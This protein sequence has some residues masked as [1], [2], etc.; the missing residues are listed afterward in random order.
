MV[1]VE[2][3]SQE[4]ARWEPA[5]GAPAPMRSRRAANASAPLQPM[6]APFFFPGAA[7]EADP[8]FVAHAMFVARAPA[9]AAGRPADTG[10]EV[11]RSG[12]ATAAL[13]RSADIESI[14]GPW[15]TPGGAS[16]LGRGGPGRQPGRRERLVRG[17]A[18]DLARIA[19]A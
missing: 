15:Y 5:T 8:E 14:E 9:F 4:I 19:R 3:V 6:H 16:E 18:S 7:P 17:G 13:R 11:W 12:D 10:V 2:P 1:P